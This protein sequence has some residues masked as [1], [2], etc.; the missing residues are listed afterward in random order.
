MN[1]ELQRWIVTGCNGYLGRQICR[2]LH[3]QG[4]AVIGISRESRN[5][6][7]LVSLG[8]KCATYSNLMNILTPSDCFVH[9]A[10]KTGFSGKWED[11]ETVN[12]K[13]TEELFNLAIRHEL[14]SFIYIS[15]VAALGYSNRQDEQVLNERSNPVLHHHEYYGR[16]KLMAEEKLQEL[17][18]GTN[19]R[20]VIL[21]PSLI[22]GRKKFKKKQDWL[23]RGVA[24]DLGSVIPFVHI[25]NLIDAVQR[26]SLMPSARGVFLVVDDDQ[27]TQR[28]FVGLKKE[29]G[30]IKYDPWVLGKTAYSLQIRIKHML[31]RLFE[32]KDILDQPSLDALMLFHTRRLRYDC[33]KLK[34]T[35][36]W[37][38]V[39][40][41]KEGWREMLP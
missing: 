8:I 17:S 24:V 3:S 20:L 40:S 39:V 6:N 37:N 18:L 33:G 5:V 22:Y 41:L 2:S 23:R 34:K 19:T 1:T 28:D 31:K 26:V 25:D 4:E 16:S 7:D 29:L 21:R 32:R 30:F 35:T 13:W 38:P 12:V 15:S 27:P 9:C 36:G 10:G 14:K 11:F